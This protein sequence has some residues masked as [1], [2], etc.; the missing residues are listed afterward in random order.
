MSCMRAASVRGNGEGFVR[1]CGVGRG[2]PAGGKAGRRGLLGGGGRGGWAA[3]DRGGAGR[4]AGRTVDLVAGFDEPSQRDGE[5]EQQQQER[6]Q[7][8][9]LDGRAA[10]LA[11]AAVHGPATGGRK[12]SIG[13]EETART[14]KCKKG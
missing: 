9:Q 5:H 2:G 6:R 14:G 8:G 7:Q 13:P 11:A 4:V 3:H 1:V 12:A 10:S